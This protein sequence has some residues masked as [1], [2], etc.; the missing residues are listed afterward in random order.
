MDIIGFNQLEGD[1]LY[2]VWERFKELLRRC[3]HHGLPKWLIVQTFYN[4]L[5]YATKLNVNAA[6]CSGLIDNSAKEA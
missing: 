2:E 6:T 5:T 3:L 1:S 4:C